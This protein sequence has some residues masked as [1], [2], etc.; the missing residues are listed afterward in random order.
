MKNSQSSNKEDYLNNCYSNIKKYLLEDNRQIKPIL[1]KDF[2]I[3]EDCGRFEIVI[4][5][6]VCSKG[7]YDVEELIFSSFIYLLFRYCE[8]DEFVLHVGKKIEMSKDI[9]PVIFKYD[10]NDSCFDFIKNIMKT[11][12]KFCFFYNLLKHESISKSERE[13]I[14]NKLLSNVLINFYDYDKEFIDYDKE[15]EFTNKD[16][17]FEAIIAKSIDK[18]FLYLKYAKGMFYE[19]KIKNISRHLLEVVK[20]FQTNKNIKIKNID[21]VTEY[22]RNII[23]NEFNKLEIPSID[24]VTIHENF[25]KSVKQFPNNVAINHNNQKITYEELNKLSNK[26][27]RLLIKKGL[28]ANSVV[29]ICMERS[30]HSISAILAIM[31]AGAIYIP[32]DYQYPAERIKFIIEDSNCKMVIT[33]KNLSELDVENIDIINIINNHEIKDFCDYNIDLDYKS[34]D[35]AYILYTSGSTGTPKGVLVTHSNVM[36]YIEAFQNEFKITSKDVI[37]QQSTYTFDTFVEEVYSSLFSG[38]TLVIIDKKLLIDSTELKKVINNN[39]V[40]LVSGTSYIIDKLNKIDGIESVKTFISGGDVLKYKHISNLL[41]KTNVYNTYGPTETT[42]C[43]TYF[44]CK[45]LDKYNSIPIGK[46]IKNCNIVIIDNYG[47]LA[48]IGIAGEICIGGE[49]VTKGYLNNTNLTN[50]KFVENPYN[51]FKLMYKTGDRGKWLPDGNI[52]FIGRKDFQ[53]KIRGYRIEIGEIEANILEYK[54]IKEV[55]VTIKSQNSMEYLCAYIVINENINISDLKKF[56][57]SKLPNYMIPTFIIELKAFPLLNNCKI[58]MEELPNPFEICNVNCEDKIKFKD[59]IEKK[60]FHLWKDVLGHNNFT[61]ED[62]FFEIGGNS[63]NIMVAVNKIAEEFNINIEAISLF[64]NP[65]IK[66]I[67]DLIRKMVSNNNIA[68]NEYSNISIAKS[69]SKERLNKLLNNKKGKK[70]T[71]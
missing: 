25:E 5:I 13:V 30:I 15:N 45:D 66:L 23:L 20:K 43:A 56:L 49:G 54:G 19:E 40:T 62:N 9:V 29:A 34:S 10:D 37:L 27:S 48:P 35:I 71:L 26:I 28:Q 3:N 1:P 63:I 41:N 68:K 55:L 39:N 44:K 38:S 31:K 67:S 8:Q 21:Y 12:E 64:N 22:E 52:E 4:D 7:I 42:V 46:P 17:E 18:V 65:N 47:N 36:S 69:K 2:Y 33:D 16:Y 14:D 58:N 24:R 11:Y 6:D 57:L 51:Q 53:I 60:V 59:E 61:T 50:K 70:I 32:I